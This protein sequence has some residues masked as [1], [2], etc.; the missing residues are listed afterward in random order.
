MDVQPPGLPSG[1]T[2]DEMK[3]EYERESDAKF[4]S[5]VCNNY[6]RPS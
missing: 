3:K 4:E 6:Q 1:K 2:I 5:H